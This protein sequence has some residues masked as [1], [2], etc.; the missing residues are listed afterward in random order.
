MNNICKKL[1]FI[2]LN[3]INLDIVKKYSLK[4]NLKFFD[5]FFFDNLKKTYSEK[6]YDLLEPWIQ[7]VSIHTGKTAKEHNIFRLGDIKNFNQQQIFESIEK[8]NKSVGVICSMNVKNNLKNPTYFISDPWTNT[9]SKPGKWNNYVAKNLARMINLNSNKK[10]PLSVYLN[11]LIILL[12]TFRIKKL[13]TYFS[14][15]FG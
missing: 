9:E 8:K 15:I 4:L 2:E 3:E 5:N 6:E 12:V 1:V 7:W 10:I 14:I 13:K 11:I